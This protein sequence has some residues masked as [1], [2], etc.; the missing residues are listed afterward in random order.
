MINNT[1]FNEPRAEA[2]GGHADR[3]TTA[4]TV[5]ASNE[6]TSADA[7][8]YSIYTT[9][10]NDHY[11][12]A[13][14]NY[15]YNL[16]Q[17]KLSN[18][19]KWRSVSRG[20]CSHLAISD[21]GQLWGFGFNDS[22]TLGTGNSSTTVTP[23]LC[24]F[25][26]SNSHPQNIVQASTAF[27]YSAALDS[28]GYIYGAGNHANHCLG[29][30]LGDRNTFE[31]KRIGN[32]KY[33]YI[34]VSNVYQEGYRGFTLFAIGKEDGKLYRCGWSDSNCNVHLSTENGYPAVNNMT[35]VA[36][37][38]LSEQKWLSVTQNK[39]MGAAVNENN[40]V[41]IWGCAWLGCLGNGENT[42]TYSPPHKLEFNG[43]SP[44]IRK[45]V[46]GG[47]HGMAL[48]DKGNIWGWGYNERYCLAQPNINNIYKPVK[49]NVLD[50]PC[51]DI[52]TELY[53]SAAV[54][55]DGKLYAWGHSVYGNLGLGTGEEDKLLR[56][57]QH[58]PFSDKIKAVQVGYWST[59][60]FA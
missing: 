28:D 7:E 40:E 2:L 17:L 52:A 49:I 46:L 14:R 20:G 29:D 45:V 11:Q 19:A 34:S 47:H 37:G 30:D 21:N 4:D 13:N 55:D 26:G 42:Q 6:K 38:V 41:Y 59:L 24:V 33:K 31:F 16:T 23:Q 51:L 54:T 27:Y 1:R 9:G 50:K 32:G 18:S 58:V 39:Y 43:P 36:D 44:V 53:H 8:S 56:Q 60:V 35:V 12:L 57:P 3:S 22:G 25:E 5:P 15:L 10:A 48:D